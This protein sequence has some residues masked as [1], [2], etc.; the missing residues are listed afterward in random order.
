MLAQTPESQP[1]INLISFP[2]I[3]LPPSVLF[4]IVDHSDPDLAL[5]AD[6]DSAD[7][8]QDCQGAAETPAG[9]GIHRAAAAGTG[10]SGADHREVGMSSL[11]G[12]EACLVQAGRGAWASHGRRVVGSCLGGDRRAG[13][14]C[15]AL[16]AFRAGQMVEVGRLEET[17]ERGLWK[18]EVETKRNTYLLGMGRVALVGRRGFDRAWGLMRIGLRLHMRM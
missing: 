12:E 7:Q 1:Q 17:L 8:T 13:E 11:E 5:P 6:P 4:F 9:A 18:G 16:G 15:R 10:N 3:I 2:H 14:A